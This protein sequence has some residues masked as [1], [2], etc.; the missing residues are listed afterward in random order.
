MNGNWKNNLGGWNEKGSRRKSQTHNHRLRDNGAYIIRAFDGWRTKNKKTNTSIFRSESQTEIVTKG[1]YGTNKP[2]VN[3]AKVKKVLVTWN[4]INNN[5]D[6]I[7]DYI[8]KK[9]NMFGRYYYYVNI[10]KTNSRYAYVYANKNISDRLEYEERTKLRLFEFLNIN[11]KQNGT[12][13]LTQTRETNRTIS[14]SE[15]EINTA[16]ERKNKI[17]IKDFDSDGD[18]IYNKPLASWKRRTFFNDG[19]RRKFTQK[20]A[21][22]NDRRNAKHWITKGVLDSEIK[23]HALS[24][25][26]AWAIS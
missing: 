11:K 23:T 7:L 4:I 20:L 14:L 9:Y 17:I 19:K 8:E 10:W 26:I 22:R 1:E 12:I 21:N 13:T 3:T 16:I 18:F 24:K 2:I 25:S 6:F 5:G 15:V